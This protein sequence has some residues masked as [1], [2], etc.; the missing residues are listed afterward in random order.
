[1][2]GLGCGGKPAR[3]N[4]NRMSYSREFASFAARVRRFIRA[5]TTPAAESLAD[6]PSFDQL[7]LGLFA[8][9]VQANPSYRRFC[10]GRAVRPGGVDHWTHVPAMPTGAFKEWEI[11]CLTP[12]ERTAVFHSSGT[13]GQQASRH[14][15]GAESLKLYEE[16][17]LAWFIDQIGTSDLKWQ[18]AILT[19]P[20][21]QAPH[22]SL[23]HMFETIRRKVALGSDGGSACGATSEAAFFGNVGQ[24]GGWRV[25][26]DAVVAA[27]Q[28]A[29]GAE[30]N[31]AASG[32]R[33]GQP[34]LMLGTAFS[35]VHLLDFLAERGLRFA[36]PEGS[37]LLETGGYKGRARALPKEKLHGL[38]SERFG[39]RAD[40][41]LC[42]YG[43]SELGSQAYD[44]AIPPARHPEHATRCF[45]FPPWARLQ[46]VSPETGREVDEG[47]SG[48]I[49]VFDLANVW[50]VMAIQ[51]EDLA[52]RRGDGFE[53]LGR[54]A[55]AEPRGCSLLTV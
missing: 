49:R 24:D 29:G 53:L 42:E 30:S 13:T 39:I 19:P 51:T 36:L 41:I 31:P 5:H 32:G 43:M 16:S 8:L 44:C 54:A 40:H 23:V 55:Q 34:V 15:H 25:D 1:M 26:A 22:S 28:K 21:A 12:A 27:L 14:F 2:Y 45:H 9:Q 10:E 11:S 35:Y 6:I 50:S 38:I 4:Q 47:E 17:S 18:L 46:I 20:P 33:L 52:R 7:A 3:V 37:R 48:L